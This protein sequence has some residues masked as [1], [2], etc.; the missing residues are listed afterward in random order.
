VRDI[1]EF[2]QLDELTGIEF[3]LGVEVDDLKRDGALRGG[4]EIDDLDEQNW[5]GLGIQIDDLGP[6]G[7]RIDRDGLAVVG[8]N[9]HERCRSRWRRVRR[10]IAGLDCL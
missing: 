1:V 8:Y 2:D 3:R 10:K 5:F 7:R 6:G 9:S 4:V